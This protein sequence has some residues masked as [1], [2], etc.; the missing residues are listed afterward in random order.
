MPESGPSTF[1]SEA[2]SSELDED[3]GASSSSLGRQNEELP[4]RRASTKPH[5][6]AAAV[7]TERRLIDGRAHPP[8]GRGLREPVGDGGGSD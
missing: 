2:K 5:Q 4:I 1:E 7:I 3:T 8:P 6:A